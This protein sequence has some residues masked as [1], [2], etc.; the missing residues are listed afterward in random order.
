L[1]DDVPVVDEGVGRFS[2]QECSVCGDQ[3]TR[4]T[5]SEF[6]HIIVN[7]RMTLIRSRPAVLLATVAFLA[8]TVGIP[9][10]HLAFHALPHDHVAGEIHYHF[11]DDD[12]DDDNDGA[13]AAQHHEADAHHH[14]DHQPFDPRHG[15]GSAAHFS[16]AIGDDAA[17]AIILTA[18]PFVPT[19]CVVE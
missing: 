1:A 5:Q 10:L 12:D 17:S 6:G 4:V 14:R 9:T 15:D 19:C 3:H 11:G 7:T 13:E 8:G 18:A 16:L 2:H